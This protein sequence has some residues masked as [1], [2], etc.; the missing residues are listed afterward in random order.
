[1]SLI[2][3]IETSG[4]ACSVALAENGEMIGSRYQISENYPHSKVLHVFIDEILREKQVDPGQLKAV[5]VSSG[6]GSYTGLRIGVSAAKGLCYALDIPLI[7]ISTLWLI[8]K[9]GS[10][11]QS[12]AEYFIPMIDA[13]RMEVY[14][15]TFDATLKP[16]SE[17][18]PL[19]IT[20]NVLAVYD[21]KKIV[22]C[23]DGSAKCQEFF[24]NK[25]NI[26][27][28]PFIFPMAENMCALSYEKFKARQFADVNYFE[29]FYLK[30]FQSQSEFHKK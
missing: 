29:P 14:T 3:N 18:Q 27:I 1:M 10:D 4:K 21:T 28:L 5:S 25:P 15:Q 17:T 20:D 23:G 6:P 2:I 11:A 16:I 13:R 12:S 7:E 9:A 30:E 8:A 19:I 26:T 22:L 24:G